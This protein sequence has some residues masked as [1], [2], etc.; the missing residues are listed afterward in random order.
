[1]TIDAGGLRETRAVRDD[2]TASLAFVVLLGLGTSNNNGH[3]SKLSFAIVFAALLL[4]GWGFVAALRGRG[5]AAPGA[6]WAPYHPYLVL[7]LLA[8]MPLTALLD[9]RLLPA[10]ALARFGAG[11][12]LEAAS[13]LL[14][15]TYV[16]FA[17][18][19]RS[20]PARWRTG[21]F[22]LFGAIVAATGVLAIR[23]SREPDIDVWTIQARAAELLLE[24]KNPYVWIAVPTS[25]QADAFTVVYNYP[26]ISIYLAI[27]GRLLGGD[28]RYGLLATIVAAGFALRAIARSGA[29][30]EGK[31]RPAII[32]DAAALSFWL[33][34]PLVFVIDRAWI[35]PL[36]VALVAF[37]V[38]AYVRQRETLAAV[39]LGV[40]LTSKQS[41]FWLVP[42][43]FVFL[44]WDVKRWAA[45]AAGALAPLL[46]FLV[47]DAARLKHNLFDFMAG[48]GPRHDALCFTAFV[49]HAFGAAFPHVT[50]F[51]LGGV[52]IAAAWWRRPPPGDRHESVLAFARA[53][54]AAYYVFFFFN[55][56][57]F[58]NYYCTVAGFAAITAAV[59]AARSSG[60][61]SAR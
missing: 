49:H 42:L 18:G 41:M 45:F 58:A 56:W 19:A 3:W 1:M 24:G 13:L 16:P 23:L 48:L 61:E 14:L 28:P 21:R 10:D 33:W 46:P 32:D 15:A 30:R 39:V 55:R 29:P 12:A 25:D 26:P 4:M 54:T 44:R 43:A 52:V 35:D 47:W 2:L 31:G 59:A 5:S 51:L 17:S 27:A 20:E 9:A 50:G 53:T 6:R 22:A 34:S 37:A 7:A 40:A 60:G 57:M 11:R 36:Q 38:L 8:A